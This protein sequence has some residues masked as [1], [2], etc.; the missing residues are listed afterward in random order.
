MRDHL[1]YSM[2]ARHCTI[3]RPKHLHATWPGCMGNPASCSHAPNTFMPRGRGAWAI[4][5]PAPMHP[6]PSCHV[7]GVHGQSRFL[8][9][10]TQHLH[11]TWPR[12]MGNP[13]SCSHAPNTFMPRGRGA[14][15]IP[16]PAPHPIAP[17]TNDK[18]RD[19]RSVLRLNSA[20]LHVE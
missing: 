1:G 12:C 11:A 6:T 8:L 7:A 5:L 16:L 4:P 10:C 13:A 9:P 20:S 15:A 3:W 17:T 14:W 19:K 18:A 2:P